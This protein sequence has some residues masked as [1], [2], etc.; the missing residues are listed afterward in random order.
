MC[1]KK[2]ST[3]KPEDEAPIA[4]PSYC[5]S[6]SLLFVKSFCLVMTSYHEYFMLGL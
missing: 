2:I 1:C 4:R 3:I 5:I 6:M